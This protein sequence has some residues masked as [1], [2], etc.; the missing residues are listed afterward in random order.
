MTKGY[1]KSNW[2]N[3]ITI[4][5]YLLAVFKEQLFLWLLSLRESQSNCTYTNMSDTC[6]TSHTPLLNHTW[7]FITRIQAWNSICHKH[8]HLTWSLLAPE[9]NHEL[10]KKDKQTLKNKPDVK[11][12]IWIY[13][14]NI[15]YIPNNSI[16]MHF[17]WN[18]F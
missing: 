11:L 6:K 10:Q 16:K 2:C 3:F 18:N 8:R 4:Y 15:I 5:Y 17:S 9:L 1:R 14:K 12:W 13:Y 7:W